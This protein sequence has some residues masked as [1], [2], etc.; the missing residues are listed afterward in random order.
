MATDSIQPKSYAMIDVDQAPKSPGIYAWYVNFS[1]GPEDW[2]VRPSADGDLA[3]DGYLDLLRK[4]ASYYDPLPIGL[5]GRGSYGA[6]WEG[7]LTLR[8]PMRQNGHSENGNAAADEMSELGRLADTLSTEERRRLMTQIL[9]ASAP[10]FSAP[11][12]IGIAENLRQRLL[13]HRRDFTKTSDWLREHPEDSG[14]VQALGKSFGQRAAARSI[15]MRHLRAWVIALASEQEGEQAGDSV[16]E[17]MKTAAGSAEW[18]L[19]RLY[20]PILGRR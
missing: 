14:K 11:L 15:P 1:A 13:T 10:I 8:N 3:I 4:Y 5:D 12:Y 16:D 20:H 7:A 17:N 18:L 2:R 19:H 6:R 9:E